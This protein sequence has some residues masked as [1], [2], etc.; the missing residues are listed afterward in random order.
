MSRRYCTVLPFRTFKMLRLSF[1]R[2]MHMLPSRGQQWFLQLATSFSLQSQS[3]LLDCCVYPDD[4]HQL[5]AR[6]AAAPATTASAPLT[7]CPCAAPPAP[8]HGSESPLRSA[9]NHLADTCNL[10]GSARGHITSTWGSLRS[11]VGSSSCS[12]RDPVCAAAHLH[13]LGE[14]LCLI[15]LHLRTTDVSQMQK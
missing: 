13:L 10:D 12:G 11:T 1:E 4:I 2:M 6:P 3:C 15:G 5:A 7:C 14:S 9:W 8:E